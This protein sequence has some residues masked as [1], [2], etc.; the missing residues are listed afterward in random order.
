[1]PVAFHLSPHVVTFDDG[2]RNA[3]GRRTGLVFV[4]GDLRYQLVTSGI[5]KIIV[6]VLIAIE[7]DLG[8][9]VTMIR[10]RYEEM[11]VRRTLA[12]TAQLIEQLLGRTVRRAAVAGGFTPLL[13]DNATSPI[14]LI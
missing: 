9:Q 6:Q 11:H 13:E 10:C 2:G 8:G 7:V 1:M 14:I 3:K 5:G 4:E 12:V